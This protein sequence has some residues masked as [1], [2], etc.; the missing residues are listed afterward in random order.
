MNLKQAVCFIII[1]FS[2]FLQAQKEA[3]NWYFGDR[4]GLS[5]NSGTPVPLTNGSIQAIEGC[6]SIS[7][8]NGNLLFYTDGETVHDRTHGV[9]Q[10][11]DNLK[12]NVSSS[13]S[14]I[15][16]PRP[17]MPER[18]FIFTVDKP[19]Y[20]DEPNDP[21][22]GVHFSEVDMS[23]NN[24]LGGVIPGQKNIP[25]QTYDPGD[26]LEAEFKS[27][28]K[29]TAIIS[30]ECES[31]WVVTQLG[32]KFYS[33]SVSAAGVNTS[34]V[35]ST[36]ATNN[37]PLLNTQGVNLTAI[38]YMKISPDGTK[39][40]AAYAATRLGHPRSGGERKTGKAFLYDFDNLTGEV[41]NEKLLLTDTY[42]YGVEFSPDSKKL[43]ITS[44]TF[45]NADRLQS[46]E[47]YQ[48]DVT[49]GDPAGTERLINSSGNNA[50]AL[51][52]APDG[53]IYRAGYPVSGAAQFK[54]LSVINEPDED[55]SGVNYDHNSI[56]I[57]PGDVKLGLPSFVQSF[58]LKSFEY[59]NICLGDATKFTV[60]EQGNYDSVIWDFGDGSVS[61]D[62]SPTHQYT[63]P[64]TYTVSLTKFLNGN[65]QSPVCKEITI[66]DI[67]AV[68]SGYILKQ[69]DAQDDDPTDGLTEFNLQL[70]KEHLTQGSSGLQ[71]FFYE[72]RNAAQNDDQNQNSLSNI[73]RN[74]QPDQELFAKVTGFGSS[75]YS[76][77]SI[78]LQTT[79]NTILKPEPVGGCD[80][81]NGNAEFNFDVISRN[82]KEELSLDPNITLSFHES[83]EDAAIG[84]NPLPQIYTSQ[85]GTVFIRAQKDNSCYGF[86]SVEL[87]LQSLPE[88]TQSY[89]IGE[90]ANNFPI[91]LGTEISLPDSSAYSYLWST[92]E[93]SAG[94]TVNSA[95]TYH[96][97]LTNDELG[98]GKEITFNV[99]K[100]DSPQISELEIQNHG[101]TN[102]IYVHLEQ[103][104]PEALYALDDINGPYQSSPQF[105]D[106]PG[107]EHTIYTKND[108]S[109]N[110]SEKTVFLFGFP[111][112]FTPNN[113]GYHDFWQPFEVDDEEYQIKQ[114]TIYD[115]YG[116]LLKQLN[117]GE[118]WDGTFNGS[119]MPSNDYWFEVQLENGKVYNNHFS[120]VRK[121]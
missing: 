77:T 49:S 60:S 99:Q 110:I 64:G 24:G 67:P 18:Y 32:N 96:L 3:G 120:L 87:I 16:V 101:I 10:N 72:N 7:D 95:G 118:K 19:N 68:P 44:S 104:D 116:K 92:G 20:F 17:T 13:Q 90:C 69:C 35:I 65:Q 39:L 26:P 23:L 29:I 62:E 66:Y 5:F 47:L 80:T 89:N 114:I 75:C 111:R 61:S 41:S 58:F 6:A 46:G 22:E 103:E 79:G 2:A 91:E 102:E 85:P 50:G 37:R 40:A 52:L 76:I 38:G 4:A 55:G 48:Y 119:P 54:F 94:I 84:Y 121:K 33:F 86:G 106:I 1:L 74:T 70:A 108:R 8:R 73:Y 81:G 107:G 117:R 109:C 105:M 34:P 88:I 115:R 97:T 28:E 12:G 25:L 9:L 15:I 113:D 53:K 59:E 45:D 57:S 30:E 83:L 14:A 27:S 43:Y 112:F 63:A 36:V 42:P 100:F 82:I 56:N 78:R 21:I 51:Q 71:V 93:N 31:Y 98:C 11:G